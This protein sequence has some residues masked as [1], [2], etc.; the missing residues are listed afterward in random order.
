MHL[1]DLSPRSPHFNLFSLSCIRFSSNLVDAVTRFTVLRLGALFSYPILDNQAVNVRYHFIQKAFTGI[2]LDLSETTKIP[3]HANFSFKKPYCESIYRCCH[4][5][6]EVVCT[7]VN[8]GVM[9]AL[10]R[11]VYEK[12]RKK[13]ARVFEVCLSL[14]PSA[15]ARRQLHRGGFLSV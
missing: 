5:T 7:S 9:R 1:P 4:Q 12:S 6:G 13:G 8:C 11:T 14:N 15:G 10:K 2:G 3:D